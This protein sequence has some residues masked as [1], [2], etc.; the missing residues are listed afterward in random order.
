M[1]G[2]LHLL[3]PSPPYQSVAPEYRAYRP[4][5]PAEIEQLQRE[6]DFAFKQSFAFCPYSPEAV[7]RYVNFLIQFH[8]FDDAMIVA[9]DLPSAR[10]LQQPDEQ[11]GG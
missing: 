5:S 1:P 4:K 8:R 6:A 9:Q 3:L 10:S 11:P 2:G 7:I